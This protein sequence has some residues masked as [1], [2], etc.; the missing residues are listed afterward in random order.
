[1]RLGGDVCHGAEE[2]DG[3]ILVQDE[4]GLDLRGVGGGADD[5]RV[6][7]TAGARAA[8]PST[9]A[10]DDPDP[11]VLVIS[12]DG[13]SRIKE[14]DDA[15][16]WVDAR[17]IH[18]FDVHIPDGATY[19]ESKTVAPGDRPVVAET[20]WGGLGL[21]AS[22]YAKIVMR[23]S[24]VWMSLTGIFN[25]HLMMAML[26]QKFGISVPPKIPP[27]PAVPLLVD[28]VLPPT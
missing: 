20:P 1:M 6:T 9:P 11:Q 17:K 14:G 26:V 8:A 28:T 4:L 21:S 27:V 23:I 10:A 16:I 19:H 3:D 24:E 7:P 2:G 18:L 12:L 5:E 13:A 22:T 15:T 25:S